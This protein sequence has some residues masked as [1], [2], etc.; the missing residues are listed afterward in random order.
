MVISRGTPNSCYWCREKIF[1]SKRSYQNHKEYGYIHNVCLIT[2]DQI[3]L[4]KEVSLREHTEI[5]VGEDLQ[6]Y[7]KRGSV[8]TW[9]RGQHQYTLDLNNFKWE[10]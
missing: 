3:E 9:E 4:R 2:V 6:E 5:I 1:G 10:G 7:Y 8:I